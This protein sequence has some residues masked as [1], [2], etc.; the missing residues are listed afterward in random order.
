MAGGLV[1]VLGARCVENDA[2]RRGPD[3]NWHLYGE[4]FNETDVQGAQMVVQGTI[5]DA[6]GRVLATANARTCPRELSPGK[7]VSYD[8]AFPN[9]KNLP[10]PA[11]HK[12]N[13]A[14]G[15]ALQGL[16]PALA[17]QPAI[18]LTALPGNR[19]GVRAS[20]QALPQ[21]SGIY[22]FCLA[23]YDGAGRIVYAFRFGDATDQPQIDTEVPLDRT[24]FP[25]ATSLRMWISAVNENTGESQFQPFVSGKIALPF[26]PQVGATP[27][28]GF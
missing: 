21:H 27:Q 26:N 5:F 1:F 11:S 10:Q 23:L 2:L 13:V 16:L 14:S 9:T 18:E 24:L 28:I 25:A 6:S 12:V 17:I 19:V 15:A 8:I 3:G 22:F 20:F 7:P 4:L